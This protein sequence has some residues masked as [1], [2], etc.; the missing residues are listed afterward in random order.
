METS[1]LPDAEFKTLLI[2]ML[3]ELRR[4]VDEQSE[5]FNKK[6]ENIKK[7]QS[8]MK[9]TL[10]EMKNTLEGIDSTVVEAWDEIRD[11]EDKE[12]ENTQ[13]E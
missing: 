11:W 10:I 13:I 7:N 9:N 1:I 4:R 2:R 3:S 12:A 6:I 5:N 8:E